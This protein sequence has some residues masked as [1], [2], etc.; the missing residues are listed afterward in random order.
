LCNPYTRVIWTTRFEWYVVRC[1][2]KNK[3]QKDVCLEE[4]ELRAQDMISILGPVVNVIRGY[5]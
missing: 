5:V 1:G 4:I 2:S 3:H